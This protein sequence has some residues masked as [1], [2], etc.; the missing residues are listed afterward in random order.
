MEMIHTYSLVHDDLPALDNDPLRR[1]KPTNHIV[2]GENMAILAGDGLLNA[3]YE[4][5][6]SAA[7]C[8]ARPAEA[9]AAMREIAVRAGVRGMVAGQTM[10]I[11]MEGATPHAEMVLYIHKHKTADLF[12]GAMAAGLL[13]AGA[14]EEQ[15]NAGRVYGENL[16]LA[17]QIVDDLL[18]LTGDA[19][20]LGKQTGM[21]A[22]A[23]K[24][25]W[26]NVYGVERSRLDAEAAI[27]NAAR[28][29]DI[30]GEKKAFLQGIAQKTLV[31]VK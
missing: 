26:P 4:T 11:Q 30:F 3:A 28:A 13:L 12:T 16:G 27:R 7:I 18:D 2:F 9:L 25:T 15:V 6:L 24:M 31:R 23:G 17:F 29:L 1:G 8:K 5:M 14:T 21:D 22:R 20:L 19:S 10:D